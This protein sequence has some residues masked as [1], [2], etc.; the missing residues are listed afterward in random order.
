M[1]YYNL[2][3]STYMTTESPY[4]SK[5]G[6]DLLD[7][8]Y[9]TG[10]LSDPA[11]VYPQGGGGSFCPP[12]Y[13]GE[14]C[15]QDCTG[16]VFSSLPYTKTDAQKQKKTN[17]DDVSVPQST[18]AGKKKQGNLPKEST[19]VLKRWLQQHTTNPYPSEDEKIELSHLTKLTVQQVSNWFI[20]A[21]RRYLPS[22]QKEKGESLESCTLMRRSKK[23]FRTTPVDTNLCRPTAVSVDAAAAYRVNLDA[24]NSIKKGIEP[25]QNITPDIGK[26]NK[27]NTVKCY[28]SRIKHTD[29]AAGISLNVKSPS[30]EMFDAESSDIITI[31]SKVPHAEA[32]HFRDSAFDRVNFIEHS[33]D[34]AGTQNQIADV[35][36]ISSIKL[37]SELELPRNSLYREN[38]EY[39][40]YDHKDWRPKLLNNVQLNP[41][42]IIDSSINNL[43]QINYYTQNV[44]NVE[45][46][47]NISYCIPEGQPFRN[48]FGE[49][50]LVEDS[51]SISRTDYFERHPQIREAV[52]INIESHG[53]EQAY[54]YNSYLNAYQVP[55]SMNVQPSYSNAM[56]MFGSKHEEE[57]A[58]KIP[59]QQMDSKQEL[60]I[61]EN[62]PGL[63]ILANVALDNS[64]E[65]YDR[66][67]QNM[68]EV[69]ASS[70]VLLSL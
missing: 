28:N 12:Q 44:Q 37:T 27:S 42:I 1:S 60:N 21:R 26:V 50:L 66:S 5:D 8:R 64:S 59:N 35:N 17:H 58:L 67:N 20:N 43:D 49:Q 29:N 32:S 65:K 34:E 57:H 54:D 10:H 16:L 63:K 47:E 14:M 13:L 2:Q 40:N 68:N 19:G 53:V 6:S 24:A 9:M 18:N 70:R 33:L 3:D 22:I 15:P 31:N 39:Q 36:G 38:N 25:V 69:N 23:R 30:I 4:L 61:D 62:A 55:Y 7:G 11:G 52:P 46:N 56:Q 41:A 45:M 48:H 51:N